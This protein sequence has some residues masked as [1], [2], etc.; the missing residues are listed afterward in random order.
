MEGILRPVSLPPELTPLKK[1]R[2][3]TRAGLAVLMLMEIPAG[4]LPER[5]GEKI[6]VDV[7]NHWA[8]KE[9]IQVVRLGWMSAQAGHRFQ[10]DL[11]V[12]RGDAA[13]IF[14][15]LLEQG[16]VEA[17]PLPESGRGPL[18]LPKGHLLY[19][20]VRRLLA[21]GIMDLDGAGNFNP[22]EKLSGS[23][24][25]A[26]LRKIRILLIAGPGVGKLP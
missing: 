8:R 7:S 26:I 21:M 10:P 16:G 2:T 15:A 17:S 25:R 14:D 9:I 23:E 22:E 11:P 3:L 18:D 5:S 1:V 4:S 20:V 6:V 24:A 19:P 12:T 13:G